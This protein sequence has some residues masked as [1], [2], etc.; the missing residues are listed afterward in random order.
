[1]QGTNSTAL[2]DTDFLSKALTI[3][4]GDNTLLDIILSLDG[5]DFCCHEYILTE[6]E[7]HSPEMMNRLNYLAPEERGILVPASQTPV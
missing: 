7:R 6:L 4:D 1:M 3:A 5:Y 2:L